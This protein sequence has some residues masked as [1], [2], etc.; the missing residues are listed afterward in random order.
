MFTEDSTILSKNS[1]TQIL[2]KGLLLTQ[3]KVPAMG[4]LCVYA[5]DLLQDMFAPYDPEFA[6]INL[7]ADA[8]IKK[9][10]ILQKYFNSDLNIR[11]IV[12]S[13]LC[14]LGLTPEDTFS[15]RLVLRILAPSHTHQCNRAKKLLAHRDSWG[16]NIFSQIN[17]WAPICPISVSRTMT[18]FP[19]YWKTPI[20]NNS[21]N[22]DID[23]LRRLTLAGK[24][25]KYPS[26]P[27]P[28]EKVCGIGDPVLLDPGDILAF[29]GAH[30]HESTISDTSRARISFDFRIVSLFDVKAGIAS[31]NIDSYSNK[32]NFQWF[33]RF[34]D[35][36]PMSIYLA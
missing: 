18:I 14:E 11:Q 3:K 25:E 33:N 13:L 17:L 6:H 36:T 9:I 24:R 8:Y 22:W 35:G 32:K 30:L 12:K 15:D 7:N 31:P 23:Q 34:T 27:N 4:K 28:T 26:V 20:A 2:L 29:A 16:S 5:R 21:A 10:N 19:Q 1:R